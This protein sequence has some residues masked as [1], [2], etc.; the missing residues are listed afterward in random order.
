MKVKGIITED[1]KPLMN[2]HKVLSVS[3]IAIET[4]D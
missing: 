3:G 2:T 1:L 4:E